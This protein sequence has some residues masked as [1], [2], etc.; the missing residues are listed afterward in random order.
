MPRSRPRTFSHGARAVLALA[1]TTLAACDDSSG[2]S[3][4]QSVH[5]VGSSTVYPFAKLVAE[6]FGTP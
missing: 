3:E 2:G 5:A 4:Q 6:Q 1:A